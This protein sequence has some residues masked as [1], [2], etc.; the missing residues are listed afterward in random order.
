MAQFIRKAL[1]YMANT[2]TKKIKGNKKK[3]LKTIIEIIKNYDAA[4]L[5][6]N[7]AREIISAI[8]S[9]GLRLAPNDQYIFSQYGLSI[10]SIQHLAQLDKPKACLNDVTKKHRA[11]MFDYLTKIIKQPDVNLS[12][13][14]IPIKL[15]IV[16]LK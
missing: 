7:E 15:V 12:I 1:N 3:D 4:N 16:E 8:K 5:T 6:A 9:K 13:P 11:P 14:N 10:E 2:I